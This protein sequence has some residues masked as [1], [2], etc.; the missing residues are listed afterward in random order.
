MNPLDDELKS[1]LKS[2]LGR[3][4]PPRGFADRVMSQVPAAPKRRWT[5]SWMAA[6]AA[7]LISIVGVSGY[8]Y[9]RRERMRQAGE[10]AKADLV[11]ALDLA[12]E[13]LQHTRA[14][15]LKNSEGHL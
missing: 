1:G 13:K 2:A 6:A 5:H 8:D 7:T 14:K 10:R 3:R 4:E 15:V 11:F 9:Q 12:S